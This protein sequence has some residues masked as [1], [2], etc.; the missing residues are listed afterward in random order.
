MAKRTAMI[1]YFVF[2]AMAWVCIFS[3]FSE[4]VLFGE[5][6]NKISLIVSWLGI[7]VCFFGCL[8]V[9]PYLLTK[10]SENNESKKENL[11]E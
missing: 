1:I 3:L 2:F 10:E 7:A 11:H 6:S 9:L 4:Q 5:G 8:S